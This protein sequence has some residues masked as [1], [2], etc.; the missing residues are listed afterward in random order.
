MIYPASGTRWPWAGT[1]EVTFTAG[2][3]AA[4]DIPKGP[5]QA[6]LVMLTAYY[7]DR[8]GGDLF[9]KAEASARRMCRRHKRWSL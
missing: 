4:N 9:I 3:E 7:E 8:E 1:A 2:F 6:L 5:R